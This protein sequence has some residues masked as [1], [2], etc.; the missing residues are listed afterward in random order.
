[1]H[2][3]LT[4]LSSVAVVVS[5]AVGCGD[6]M[7]PPEDGVV[8]WETFRADATK[9][10]DGREIYVV[11]WDLRVSVDELRRR[12]D[13]YVAE[14]LGVY[15][16][17][18]VELNRGEPDIWSESERRN[19]TYCVSNAFGD[20][21]ERMVREMESASSSWELAADIDFRYVT[22]EDERCDGKNEHVVFS[23]MP[24]DKGGACAFFPSDDGCVGRS[25]VIDIDAYKD[26]FRAPTLTTV[27]V[28]RHELGHVL[29]LRHE[30][31]RLGLCQERD[32]SYEDVT[33]YDQD[34]VMH[35]PWCGNGDNIAYHLSEHDRRGVAM[36]YGPAKKSPKP[37][38]GQ[39]VRLQHA[40]TGKCL[41]ADEGTNEIRSWGDCWSSPTME[42]ALEDAGDGAVRIRHM[43]TNTCV[44]AAHGGV[45]MLGSCKLV[46]RQR[47]DIVPYYA[48]YRLRNRET[49]QALVGSEENGGRAEHVR[50]HDTFSLL[51]FVDVVG[52]G[53]K[54]TDWLDRDNPGGTGDFETLD[55]F[56]ENDVCDAPLDVMCET[57][58]GVPWQ[59]SG[60][61]VTCDTKTGLRCVHAEQNNGEWCSDYRVRFLC[62]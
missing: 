5:L 34:S 23:V 49:G 41:Y 46:D 3:V 25:V 52:E 42:Y 9:V 40:Y 1:M 53:P 57:V 18:T 7:E 15:A 6:A 16:R 4:V 60:Q 50:D 39:L 38:A 48:G 26:G 2:R 28:L 31:I 56:T 51:F 13:I 10:V 59:Q 24:W 47:Y 32:R 36:L 44:M 33:V 37:A 45:A 20:N 22:G 17:S 55:D 58:E 29:G 61:V 12:Y 54:W 43:L 35:Y 21:K 62:R 27:G 30:H 19:L 11:E 8:S 14:A